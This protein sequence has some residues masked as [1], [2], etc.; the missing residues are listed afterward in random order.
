MTKRDPKIG[1]FVAAKAVVPKTK[2]TA[3]KAAAT[4]KTAKKT[5]KRAVVKKTVSSKKTK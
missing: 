2:K 4:K 1:R 5:A 3:K